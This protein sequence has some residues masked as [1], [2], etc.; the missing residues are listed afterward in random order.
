M[1]INQM[2]SGKE[3]LG[4]TPAEYE[5]GEGRQKCNNNIIVDHYIM[6]RPANSFQGYRTGHF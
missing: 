6:S 1:A 3:C 4:A 2:F 5:R